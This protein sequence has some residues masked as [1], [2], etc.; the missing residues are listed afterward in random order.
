[1]TQ[2]IGGKTFAGRNAKA[3]NDLFL[4][5]TFAATRFGEAEAADVLATDAADALQRLRRM[6]EQGM[7]T[8]Y[9]QDG[10]WSCNS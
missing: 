5:S 7:L 9:P 8:A 2:R 10:V 4:L 1:M 3:L 6:A